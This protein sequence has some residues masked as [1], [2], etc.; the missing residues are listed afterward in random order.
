MLLPL[1]DNVLWNSRQVW[2]YGLLLTLVHAQLQATWCWPVFPVVDLLD[3]LH[4]V[5]NVDA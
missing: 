4:S 3:R 2:G 5:L 1:S